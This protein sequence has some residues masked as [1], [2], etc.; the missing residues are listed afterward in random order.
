MCKEIYKIKVLDTT[1]VVYSI[2]IDVHTE[3]SEITMAIK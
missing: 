2:L 1:L 3:T